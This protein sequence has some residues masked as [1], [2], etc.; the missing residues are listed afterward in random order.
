[1]S[2]E[3]E[4][5]NKAGMIGHFIIA[6]IAYI[7][8]GVFMVMYSQ[9]VA[10]GINIVFGIVMLLYGIIQ[11]ISFFLN[12]DKEENLFME[13]ALGVI[14]LGLGVFALCAPAIIQKII[15]YTVGAILI[16]DSLVNVKR[17]FNLKSMGFPR[18]YVLLAFATI[19]IILGALCI[20]LY[21]NIEAAVIIFV[22]IAL[23]YEGLASL[24]TMFMVSR[25]KK[26]VSK[27]IA[28]SEKL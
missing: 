15:F 23:I 9:K 18:W 19:G 8:L 11:I 27:E 25:I 3:K 17:A 7:V 5:P 14:A 22:G 26:K 13:L 10:D 21:M 24:I 4:K 28:L 6:A 1:M 12:K 16:I 20:I 2:K